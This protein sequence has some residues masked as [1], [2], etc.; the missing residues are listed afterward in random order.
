MNVTYKF[1]VDATYYHTL[2]DRYYQQRRFPFRL[3]VQFG[4]L[5]LIIAGAFV[6][7]TVVALAAKVIIALITIA[8]IFFGGIALT[9]WGVYRRLKY[10]ADFGTQ[11]TVIMS[12]EGLAAS[13]THSQGN[14]SWAAYPHAVR[15]ADGIMLLRRGVIRWLPDSALLVGTRE[16]ATA[17]VRSKS[18]LR[19]L[20]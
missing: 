10:R 1:N 12:P 16:D 2:I 14:W 4:F 20:A 3:P 5:A 6:S 19:D 7:T 17:L 8:L 15:H 13:G 18:A 11:A 9:K